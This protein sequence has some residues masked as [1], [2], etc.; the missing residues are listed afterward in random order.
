MVLLNIIVRRKR[1]SICN[2]SIPSIVFWTRFFHLGYLS[3]KIW[4][5]LL[6]QTCISLEQQYELFRLFY[7]DTCMLLNLHS[8]VDQIKGVQRQFQNTKIIEYLRT[9]F[10]KNLFQSSVAEMHKIIRSIPNAGESVYNYG[11][12]D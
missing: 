11:N 5:W 6:M 4:R 10:I 8:G 2:Y 9:K 3:F 12:G 7:K 1:N